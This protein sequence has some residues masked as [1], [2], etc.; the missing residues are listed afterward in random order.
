MEILE[1]IKVFGYLVAKHVSDTLKSTFK[2]CSASE[3]PDNGE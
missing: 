1:E 2:L 3:R